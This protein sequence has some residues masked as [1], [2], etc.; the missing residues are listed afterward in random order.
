MKKILSIAVVMFCSFKVNEEKKY[1]F[2]FTQAELNAL[3]VSLD[4]SE[5]PH[6]TVQG[7]KALIEKQYVLQ[8]DTTKKK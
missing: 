1:Y 3:W 7:I 8:L 5:A 2:E 6:V 4:K